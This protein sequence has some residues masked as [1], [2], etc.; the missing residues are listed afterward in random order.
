MSN[1]KPN[2]KNLRITLTDDCYTELT[3]MSLRKRIDVKDFI[4][5]ILEKYSEK[6]KE[7]VAL[8]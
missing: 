1:S 7:T 5:E 2:N 3:I 4:A 6:K 8:S